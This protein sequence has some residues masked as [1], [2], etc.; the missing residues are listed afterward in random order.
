MLLKFNELSSKYMVKKFTEEDVPDILALCKGNP[1]YYKYFKSEPTS[2]N[3]KESLTNLPPNK[4][5]EDKY[6][7]GFYDGNRLVAIL[8]L[9]AGYPNEDIAYIGWFM[10]NRE[11]QG[12]GVGTAIISEAI[13][14][15]KEKHF[16]Y[17]QLGYIK[18]NPEARNF[19]MK[20]KF[21]PTGGEVETDS[22]TIVKMQREI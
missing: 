2:E 17:V 3:I 8:D 7:V 4:T 10:M 9:I 1:I 18:G 5:M 21:I 19:W 20:N 14:Y 22:Y 12:A 16:C 15:L 11:F 6:F 13:S